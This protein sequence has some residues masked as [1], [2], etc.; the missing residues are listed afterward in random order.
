EHREHD[1]LHRARRRCR[2]DARERADRRDRQGADLCGRRARADT[3]RAATRW[4]AVT[5]ARPRMIQFSDKII[6]HAD[7]QRGRKAAQQQECKHK[8]MEETMLIDRRRI[9]LPALA[10]ALPLGLL[11]TVPAFAE[12]PDLEAVAKKVEAFRAAQVDADAKAFDALCA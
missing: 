11:R 2:A 12:S 8:R 7:L 10:V 4:R 9:F 1:L 3:Q 5:P 6:R